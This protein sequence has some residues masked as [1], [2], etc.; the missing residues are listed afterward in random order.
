TPTTEANNLETD[1][2]CKTVSSFFILP[3]FFAALNNIYR[4]K[5]NP[6]N[7]KDITDTVKL[8]KEILCVV[9]AKSSDIEHGFTQN[10]VQL[11]CACT[12]NRNINTNGKR[13]SVG[14]VHGV[15]T[16]G[17]KWFFTVVTTENQIGAIHVPYILHL[18]DK[19]IADK[20]L[21]DDVRLLFLV[22]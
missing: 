7:F 1:K 15:V 13:R 18:S 3:K 17:E 21:E 12:T 22:L 8:L 6:E 5:E 9:E 2:T 16:T 19:D 14:Y 10:L 20:K 4:I 11:K